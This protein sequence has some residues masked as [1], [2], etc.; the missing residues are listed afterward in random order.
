MKFYLLLVLCS[1]LKVLFFLHF[2]VEIIETDQISFYTIIFLIALLVQFVADIVPRPDN[3]FVVPPPL[4]AALHTVVRA[5]VV[6]GPQAVF[7]S[8]LQAA[9]PSLVV[10]TLLAPSLLALSPLALAAFSSVQN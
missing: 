5:L 6:S 1:V 9:V 4:P 10:P 3:R 2:L 7:P 8:P